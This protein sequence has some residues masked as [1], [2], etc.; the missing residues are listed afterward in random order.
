MRVISTSTF[1]PM[2]LLEVSSERFELKQGG[3]FGRFGGH[4]GGQARDFLKQS[5]FP[6]HFVAAQFKNRAGRAVRD[7][8]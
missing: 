1:T 8:D 5:H 4:D 6:N 7:R 3:H 2:S